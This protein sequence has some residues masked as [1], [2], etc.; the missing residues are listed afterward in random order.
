M[1]LGL[2][3]LSLADVLLGEVVCFLGARHDEV[4]CAVGKGLCGVMPVSLL[5]SLMRKGAE[6]TLKALV[7]SY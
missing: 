7:E 6:L 5:F 1:C 2:A 4:W 3:L